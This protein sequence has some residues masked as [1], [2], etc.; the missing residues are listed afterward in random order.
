MTKIAATKMKR[1]FVKGA[2]AWEQDTCIDFREDE[3]GNVNKKFVVFFVLLL[4]FV[5]IN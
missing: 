4:F 3:N 1:I 5:R 2:K